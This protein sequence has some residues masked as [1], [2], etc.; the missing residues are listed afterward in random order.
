MRFPLQNSL[1]LY[2]K[3]SI[4]RLTKDVLLWLVAFVVHIKMKTALF[5]NVNPSVD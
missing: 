4:L 1:Y 5:Q 3:S 2:R